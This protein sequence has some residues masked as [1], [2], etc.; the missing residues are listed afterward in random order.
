MHQNPLWFYDTHQNVAPTHQNVIVQCWCWGYLG[1]PV[2]TLLPVSSGSWVRTRGNPR[3]SHQI[4]DDDNDDDD[5]DDDSNDNDD[6]DDDDDCVGRS[7]GN[8][9]S[10]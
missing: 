5:D 9:R 10:S 7:H 6:D 1:P 3:S 4:G 8:P 2:P